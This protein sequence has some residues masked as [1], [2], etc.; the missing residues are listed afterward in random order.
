M[1]LTRWQPFRD[2]ERW[3]PIHEM[4]N[5]QQEMNRL[6]DRFAHLGNDDTKI[7]T[8]RP[9]VEIEETDN[10]FNLKLEVPGLEVKDLD[11]RVAEDT[12]KISGERKKESKTEEKGFV[13]SEFSYG[14][15]E[16][17]IPLPT[18]IQNDQVTAEYK[19]GI[20]TMML[21]KAEEEKQK[22][23]KVNLG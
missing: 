5:L 11:I 9:S 12:V 4:E 6:F 3:E 14:R 2:I 19:N 21:P 23:V 20:L 22:V 1:K 8:V 10:A 18:R 15:F 7:M 13:R 16:R 17:V